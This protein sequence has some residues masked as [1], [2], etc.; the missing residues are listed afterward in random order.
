MALYNF[1]RV[2]IAA[3]IL[4]DVAFSLYCYRKFQIDG[5]AVQLVMLIG[6]TIITFVLVGYLI[7]FNK[8]LTVLRRAVEQRDGNGPT[9]IV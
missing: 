4:F 2:L 6:S 8:S 1:H 3:A 9:E 7:Y 5:H